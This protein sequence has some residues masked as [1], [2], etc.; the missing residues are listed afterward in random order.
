MILART[1]L[2]TIVI[3]VPAVATAPELPT[4]LDLAER[5]AVEYLWKYSIQVLRTVE[6]GSNDFSILRRY[7]EAL[8]LCTRLSG[9]KYEQRSVYHMAPG[10]DGLPS[11]REACEDWYAKNHLR[12][13]YDP[14]TRHVHLKDACVIPGEI[15]PFLILSYDFRPY[16]F[17]VYELYP[18]GD[19]RARVVDDYSKMECS[20]ISASTISEIRS[21]LAQLR[22]RVPL[23]L[24]PD[25]SADITFEFDN[26]TFTINEED[27]DQE[28]AS[29]LIMLSWAIF[30]ESIDRRYW[31]FSRFEFLLRRKDGSSSSRVS[32][33][34][35][36]NVESEV[37]GE[38]E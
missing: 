9:I 7:P 26:R 33:R 4:A 19:V 3:A 8:D 29:L 37:P 1:I 14:F 5:N 18:S 21:A 30:D 13:G 34:P 20:Q 32:R 17:H 24:V 16:G 35:A 31:N 23:D 27:L 10:R 25:M 11:F 6:A 28:L 12:I 2:L 22:K 15:R 38:K 36:R